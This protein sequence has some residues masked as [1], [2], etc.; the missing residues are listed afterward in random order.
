MLAGMF[1]LR[2]EAIARPSRKSIAPFGQFVLLDPAAPIE[3][4][5][6]VA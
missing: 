1:M 6:Q 3:F 2:L 5:Y 4:E